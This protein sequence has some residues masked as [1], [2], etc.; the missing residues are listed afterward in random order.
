[1]LAAKVYDLSYNK[2]DIKH[3]YLNYILKKSL[4]KKYKINS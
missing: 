1:M 2:L 4:T 3:W